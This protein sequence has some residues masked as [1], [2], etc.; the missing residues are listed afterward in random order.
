M[1]AFTICHYEPLLYVVGFF[2]SH[3]LRLKSLS[4]QTVALLVRGPWRSRE[5]AGGEH[6][7]GSPGRGL[8]VHPPCAPAWPL[9]RGTARMEKPRAEKGMRE[10]CLVKLFG[11]GSFFWQRCEDKASPSQSTTLLLCCQRRSEQSTTALPRDMAATPKPGIWQHG[12]FSDRPLTVV[13]SAPFWVYS[14]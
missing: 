12:L 2:R 9:P 6:Q 5:G 7:P 1:H 8:G 14:P 3:W 4:T 11:H 10:E 13:C